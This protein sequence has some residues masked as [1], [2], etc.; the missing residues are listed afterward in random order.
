M[1]T[2]LS[3][4]LVTLTLLAVSPARAQTP[5][6]EMSISELE[7]QATELHPAALYVLAARLLA[8]GQGQAAANW[9]YAGQIRYRFLI[10]VDDDRDERVLFGALSEQVG[11][12]VNEY[13]A[14]NV[15]EWLASID[16]ALEW[17]ASNPNGTTSKSNHPEALAQVR[18]GLERLRAQIEEQRE[19]IP[20]QR[21]A[22]GLENR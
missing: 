12:P 10:E 22:N 2:L 4:L 8:N 6:E 1:K 9:M 14:G 19:L 13:I 5:L 21:A 3:C 11:R 17:D 20:K 18:S 7:A 15:D 16:W